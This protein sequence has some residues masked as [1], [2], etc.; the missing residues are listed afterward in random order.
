MKK[1]LHTIT[2]IVSFLIVIAVAVIGSLV[3]GNQ[4]SSMWYEQV[5]PAITPPNWVFGPVWT[6]LFIL[7]ATSLAFAWD[8]AKDK[9]QRSRVILSYGLNFFFN[10]SWSVLYF[11]L[12]NP[13]AAFIDLVALLVS[14]VAMIG[15]VWRRDIRAAYLLLPYLLWVIFAGILNFLS[16]R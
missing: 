12:R 4:V 5:K 2:F 9:R 10:I 3:M 15:V 14:I 11:A 8:S 6:L 16:I 7:L 13:A 1:R